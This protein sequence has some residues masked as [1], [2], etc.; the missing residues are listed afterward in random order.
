MPKLVAL[1]PKLHGEK[2]WKRAPDYRFAGKARFVTIVASEIGLASS[3]MPLGFLKTGNAFELAALVSWR[4]NENLYIAPNGTWLGKYTPATL[5]AHPFRLLRP[6]GEEKMVLCVDEESDRVKDGAGEEIFF[7]EKQRP[8]KAVREVLSL[9]EAIERSRHI[10]ALAVQA[11]AH[12]GLIVPWEPKSRDGPKDF[13]TKG[14][15]KIDEVALNRLDNEVFLKLRSA[16]ALPIAYGQ[17]FSTH[18]LA[19]LRR[20]LDL[21]NHMNKSKL[22]AVTKEQVQEM[23]NLKDDLIRFN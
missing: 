16:G 17:I 7:D 5:R 1:S 12:A 10:T 14:F 20:L 18:Q 15:Y 6:K 4:S 9:C 3:D 2:T 8:S 22:G 11:L 19:S 13:S 23:F 21:R